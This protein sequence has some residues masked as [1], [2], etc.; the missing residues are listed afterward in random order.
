M[1]HHQDPGIPAPPEQPAADAY[2]RGYLDGHLAGWRD[3]VAAQSAPQNAGP[4]VV[5][6]AAAPA[7]VVPTVASPPQAIPTV[8]APAQVAPAPAVQVRTTLPVAAPPN[9]MPRQPVYGGGSPAEWAGPHQGPPAVQ[10]VPGQIPPRLAATGGEGPSPWGPAPVPYGRPMPPDPVAVAARKARRETQNINIT[11]YVASLLMVAAAALF[12]GSSLPVAA[13]LVG[14]WLGTGLFY[15]AGLVLHGRVA[16]LRPAAVAFTGTGLA[17]VPFA[18]L[19]TYNLGFPDAPGVW[20]ATSLIGTAAYAFAAVRLQSRLVV[21]L[22][23]AFLLSAAWSSVAIVGAALAWYFAALIVFSAALSLLG[24]FLAGRGQGKGNAAALYAK[25]L[26]EL[27]P[28]FAPT[29][30]AGS[31]VVG[32]MLNAGDHLLVLLAGVAHYAIMLPIAGA[33]ARRWNYWGLRASLTLAAPFAG[34]LVQPELAW[35]AGAFTVVLAAQLLAV[36]YARPVATSYLGIGNSLQWDIRAGI[37][38]V[39]AGGLVWSIGLKVQAAADSPDGFAAWGLAVGLIA[40]MAVVPAV[41][42]KGEWLPLPAVSAVVV[43]SPTL[44]AAEW[45]AL[46]AI[47]LAYAVCRFAW[48]PAGVWRQAWLVSARLL[49]TALVASSLAAFV[50]PQP[51]KAEFVMAAIAVLAALQL[52]ADTLLARRGAANPVT[53]Y[54]AAAWSVVGTLLV[55][56]LSIAAIGGL[57]S[58]PWATGSGDSK[59]LAFLIAATAMGVSAAMHSLAELLRSREWSPAEFVAPLYLVTASLATGPVF[60]AGGAVTAWAITM[61]YLLLG[62]ALVRSRTTG[63]HRQLY[64][65]TARAASIA[66]AVALYQL[67]AEMVPAPEVAGA[68]VG[69][70]AVL[71]VAFLPQLAILIFG[72]LSGRRPA[73]LDADIAVTLGLVVVVAAAGL[74][75]VDP[76]DWPGTAAM[77]AASAGMAGLLVAIGLARQPLPASQYAAPSALVFMAL[78]SISQQ[79]QLLMILGLLTAG[80]GVVAARGGTR[81]LRSIHF[82]LARTAVAAFIGVLADW[83]S[84]D[85]AVVSLVL[86]AALLAQL[87]LQLLVV[88]GARATARV[89]EPRLLAASMWLLLA[90]QL[91]LPAVYLAAAGGFRAPGTGLRSVVLVL[92]AAVVLTAVLAQVLRMQRGASYVALAAV[93][94]AAAV[95]APMLWPGATALALLALSLALI[96]WRCI[97]HTPATPEMRWFW[98]VA[99]GALLITAHVVDSGAAMGIFAGMW[100]V[101]GL[102]LLAAVQLMELKW[103]T[104]P[105]ALLVFL[106]ALLFRGQVLDLTDRP[107]FS[108]LAGFLVVVGT[109]YVVRLILLDLADSHHIQRG[110][111]VPVAVAGGAFFALWSMLDTDAVIF[112]ALAF[113]V[114]AALACLEAPAGQRRMFIDASVLACAAVWFWACS[115]YVDLGP[116][117]AVQWCAMALGALSV[118]RYV[119]K[120]QKEGKRLLMAAAALASLGAVMTIFSGDTVQQLV[121]LLVFV[122]LLAVGMS[123]DE[124]VFTIWGA[125]GVATAVLWYLRGFTYILLALLAL[126]L[127]GFA[128]WRL[129]RRKPA[130]GEPAVPA[131]AFPPQW[132]GQP[133]APSA[134]APASMPV[135]PSAPWPAAPPPA[136][137]G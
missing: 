102:A 6:A 92:L 29:G 132:A 82:L 48:S 127:I 60:N 137:Q 89:G 109:L 116:F 38:G 110:A 3:A 119:G 26:A 125:V 77:V 31:L 34:W 1:S 23:L 8:A 84:G 41:L 113:T 43:V 19:A 76:G 4:V 115:S 97:R 28:W 21:Y 87:P 117:W 112:G 45:T 73:G 107:G 67:W 46:L 135:P 68:P 64:W 122:A 37:L 5:P 66:L 39:A 130:G 120:Q 32:T 75:G 14:V 33:P 98:L 18:G 47:A 99:T 50:P 36:A 53:G 27:G 134:Q 78:C 93:A 40:A 59:R 62:G 133:V 10:S 80:S 114:A 90:T 56:A 42:P 17:I 7:Q 22:S 131:Q 105:G 118:I 74:P 106:A 63:M 9:V 129:N 91:A 104:L 30:I 35:A 12:V 96:T 128:I 25:P 52:L 81:L 100:L 65:W 49:V 83:I 69:I 61:A 111:L 123:L 11:L 86:C 136:D 121:S 85:P 95:V 94:G 124:R 13:R 24:H 71:L 20:L 72:V 51:G 57:L 15:A 101:A 16:R 79:S 70:W 58:E 108:A 54:S 44:N 88:R 103:L 55:V 126:A 2:R